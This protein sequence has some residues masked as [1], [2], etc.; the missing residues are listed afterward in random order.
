LHWDGPWHVLWDS[1]Y[2]VSPVYLSATCH[3]LKHSVA[4]IYHKTQKALVKKVTDL[5][6]AGK[7][8]DGEWI[9]DECLFTFA[10]QAE[11][12][13]RFATNHIYR[14]ERSR[15]QDL[16]LVKKIF[17]VCRYNLNSFGLLNFTH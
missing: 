1:G 5:D 6:S 16:P 9:D 4:I 14:R 10:W 8:V 3:C 13:A 11:L 15:P 2:H 17:Q 12:A 7:Y